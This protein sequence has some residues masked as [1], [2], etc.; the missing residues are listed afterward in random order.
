MSRYALL[1][2]NRIQLKFSFNQKIIDQIKQISKYEYS[3][4][5]TCWYIPFTLS[6]CFLIKELKFEFNLLLKQAANTLFKNNERINEKLSTLPYKLFD[7]QIEGVKFIDKL[8]GRCLLADEMGLGKTVQALG[9]LH[10]HPIER[11]AVVICPASL[12]YN[13]KQEIVKWLPN[14]IVYVCEGK[15]IPKTP[16]NATIY[17]I[18][19]DILSTGKKGEYS[20]QGGW[21]KFLQKENLFTVIIDECHKIKNSKTQRTIATKKICKNVPNIIGISGTPIEN[22][23]SEI[24]NI[25]NIINP[26][27]FPNKLE[28]LTNYC[29]MKNNG[30]G[31]TYD[32]IANSIKEKKLFR[33]QTRALKKIIMKVMIRRLK[34]SVWQDMPKK[35]YTFVPFDI[36]DKTIQKKYNT[37]EKDL[38]TFL[39]RKAE[40]NIKKELFKLENQGLMDNEANLIIEDIQQ[41]AIN[42]NNPLVKMSLLKQIATKGILKQAIKWLDVFIANETKIVVFVQH[43]DIMNELVS[44]FKNKCVKVDGAVTG[45]NRQIAVEKFQKDPSTLL[46]FG[47]LQAASEGITLTA[48]SNIAFLEYPQLPGQLAQAI[49]RI[50]RIGQVE[51]S[52]NIYFLLCNRPSI[53]NIISSLSQKQK[54]IDSTIDSEKSFNSKMLNELKQIL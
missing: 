48:A 16:L 50:H 41:K 26:N 8:N 38:S 40:K 15:T 35:L 18:N 43:R 54:D 46:F 51:S 14:E 3:S 4:E 37:I 7:Y 29:H 33:K 10:L 21:F 28:F 44:H 23:P 2:E 36:K 53:K 34:V 5:K 27:L 45:K 1:I 17:I 11:P 6:N 49:D 25:I 12:K 24:Y 47:N 52:I 39:K 9:Y 22:T 31:N 20:L 13:W 32:N 42:S 19:Y 30:F